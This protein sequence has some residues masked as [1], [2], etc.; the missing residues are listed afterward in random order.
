MIE[1]KVVAKEFPKEINGFIYIPV[2]I[3]K[4]EKGISEVAAKTFKLMI[5]ILPS[6]S[7]SATESR[8]RK[9][10]GGNRNL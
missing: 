1:K 6:I 10:P 7:P 3:G 8:D 2:T 4:K 9:S 5:F